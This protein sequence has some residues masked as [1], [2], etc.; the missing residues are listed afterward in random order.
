MASRC[1]TTCG[2]RRQRAFAASHY[3]FC[4]RSSHRRSSPP[5]AVL[6]SPSAGVVGDRD[7]EGQKERCRDDPDA[8]RRRPSGCSCTI[9]IRQRMTRSWIC[10]AATPRS[11]RP[12]SSASPPATSLC[13]RAMR[14]CTRLTRDA[15]VHTALQRYVR[16]VGAANAT[17]VLAASAAAL[18][19]GTF[20]LAYVVVRPYLS[21][22]QLT[23]LSGHGVA[24]GRAGVSCSWPA[25][26]REQP[27]R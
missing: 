2:P 4:S 21:G 6:W 7:M 5:A 1:L 10:S 26:G 19:V 18:P 11:P 9:S 8:S 20:D 24:Y 13:S 15:A 27:R 14:R 22:S 16:Q 3:P 23:D 25:C 12:S 17:V